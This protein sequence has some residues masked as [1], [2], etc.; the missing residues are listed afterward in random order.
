MGENTYRARRVNTVYK[1][2]SRPRFEPVYQP[3]YKPNYAPRYKPAY[4]TRSRG[5]ADKVVVHK[6]K[7][8]VKHVYVNQS[9]KHAKK[10]K[11]FEKRRQQLA[12]ACYDNPRRCAD[13]F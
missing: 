12:Q 3:N 8:I 6:H 7:V 4:A 1:P 13:A 5:Q 11:K 2:T 10:R 9:K